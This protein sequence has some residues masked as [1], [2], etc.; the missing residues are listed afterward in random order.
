[1]L[2]ESPR[3]EPGPEWRGRDYV[4]TAV[5]LIAVAGFCALVQGPLWSQDPALAAVNLTV[6]VLFVFTGWMLRRE[7]GQR[8]VAWALMGAGLLRSLDFVDAWSGASWAIY[9][10]L[11]GAAD[12]VLGAYALLR[13][14]NPS[15]LRHQRV[16]LALLAGWMLVG[17]MLIAMTALPQWDGVPASSW[18]PA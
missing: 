14:P 17:R 9:D 7:P 13:Y 2:S 10:L 1:M 16:Y 11:F 3:H 5:L 8:G 18:W 15:L 6:S 4:L 12:R